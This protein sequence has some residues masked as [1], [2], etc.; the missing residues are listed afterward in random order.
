MNILMI[1][2]GGS[3]RL[4]GQGNKRIG[5]PASF[6]G[7]KDKCLSHRKFADDLLA[8]DSVNVDSLINTYTTQYDDSLKGWYPPGTILSFNKPFIDDDRLLNDALAMIEDF[9]KYEGIL[10]VRID[11]MLKPN[12]TDIF[13]LSDKI[14]FSSLISKRYIWRLANRRPRIVQKIG[15]QFTG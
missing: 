14:T 6:E 9:E 7:Q 11:L 10:F 5:E 4:G 3:F 15:T 2:A 8:R 12:F 13:H 1:L